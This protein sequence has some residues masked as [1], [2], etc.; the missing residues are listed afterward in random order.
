[1]ELVKPHPINWRNLL[2]GLMFYEE[3]GYQY[4]EL[5]WYAPTEIMH[6]T[7]DGPYRFKTELG[8]P[9]GSAE[10][11]FL[12]VQFNQGLKPGKYVALTPCFRDEEE[13]D[14]N[15]KQFAKVELYITDDV[16]QRNLME[17]IVTCQGLLYGAVKA[18]MEVV[19]MPD[20]SYDI[21]CKGIEL[22]SYGMREHNGHKWIYA[23][24]IAEPRTSMVSE[25]TT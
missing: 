7:Y 23:T 16:S 1:M 24:G 13:T 22:G 19:K 12:H 17:T 20:D 21:K 6:I 3:L 11:A 18:E 2:R 9:I 25:W 4:L 8:D 10:Q 5:P 15:F 14:W